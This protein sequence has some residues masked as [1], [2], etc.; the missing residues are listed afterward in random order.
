MDALATVATTEVAPALPSRMVTVS[1]GARLHF[2]FANL[3]LAADRLYGS[4]GVA[5][6]DPRVTVEARPA[7][8]VSADDPLARRFAERSVDVL[9]V[10]GADVTVDDALPRHVGL[11]SGTQ[12]A[13]AVHA[14]VAHAHDRSPRVRE[15][16]PALGRGGRSGVGVAA[17]ERGGFVLDAGHPPERF[18]SERPPDGSWDVPAVNARHAVPD[19]WRFLLVCPDVDA[20]RCGDAEESS[21]RD[22]VANADA[23]VA[24]RIAGT[25]LHRVLPGIAAGDH[26]AFGAGVAAVGRLNGRWYADAQ[27][28][29]YRPPAGALVDA[30]RDSAA[31]AG[32]GQSSWGPVVYGVTDAAHADE[33]RADGRAA[34]DDVGV[35]GDVRVVRA[36]NE[37][38][39]VDAP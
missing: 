6:A 37:G 14:A 20:G 36:S 10:D 27:G 26:R 2:G 8:D 19:A 35:D 3:S 33:A 16:A 28:G 4:M 22:V 23:S 12:L 21:M 9:D 1:T 29:T 13:L 24:D 38:A 18:T 17:F 31:V 34:L 7:S 30:L 25:V 39:R 11:G 5:L 15:H 32:A